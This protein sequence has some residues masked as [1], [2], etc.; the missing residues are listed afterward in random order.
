MA[1]QVTGCLKNGG[2][3]LCNTQGEGDI[4]ITLF[5]IPSLSLLIII[6]IMLFALCNYI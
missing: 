5:S 4:F 3:V 2:V 1:R 6:I